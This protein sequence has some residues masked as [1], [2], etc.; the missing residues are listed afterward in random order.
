MRRVI[1]AHIHY[2]VDN[3]YFIRTAKAAGYENPIDQL[4][5]EYKANGVERA[6][7]MGNHKLENQRDYPE[8]TNFCAGLEAEELTRN[9]M[10]AMLGPLEERVRDER[11]VGIKIYA[12]YCQTYVGDPI[13]DPVYELAM[14]YDKPVAVHMGATAGSW[15]RLRYSQP[16]TLDEPASRFPKVRFVMCHFGNPFLADAAAV[17][18][19]CHNVTADLSGLLDGDVNIDEYMEEQAGYVQILKSWIAYVNSYD[20]FM[21]G[22]DW[23]LIG[24]EKYIDFISRIIPEKHHEKVFFDNANRIYGLGL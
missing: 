22:T 12:G 21:Y 17:M 11:C 1:D 15:G 3:E 9:G 24:S 18:D 10:D 5:A 14:R 13:Y 16:L 19:K 6:I 8:F 23:P 20:R 2:F 4:R 7:I